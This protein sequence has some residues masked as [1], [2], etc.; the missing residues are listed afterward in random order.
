ME[1]ILRQ[2]Q[3]QALQSQAFQPQ[4]FQSHAHLSQARQSQALP[5]QD[6]NAAVGAGGIAEEKKTRELG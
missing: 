2:F 1:L 4:A 3:S 6:P 5:P